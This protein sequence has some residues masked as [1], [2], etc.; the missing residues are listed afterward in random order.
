MLFLFNLSSKIA[1]KVEAPVLV[2]VII[3]TLEVLL[4]LISQSPKPVIICVQNKYLLVTSL[5]STS[6]NLISQSPK[7]VII[8]VQNKYLLVTS[9]DSTSGRYALN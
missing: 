9:L 2:R 8:C 7:P 3:R 1:S 5:D 4:Y 6:G